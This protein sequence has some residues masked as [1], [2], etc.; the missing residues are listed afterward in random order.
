MNQTQKNRR[1]TKDNFAFSLLMGALEA[2]EKEDD[3]ERLLK[4]MGWKQVD[5]I[6]DIEPLHEYCLKI[7]TAIESGM[8]IKFEQIN[9]LYMAK[10]RKLLPA[11]RNYE[12]YDLR[13]SILMSEIDAV[14]VFELND[15]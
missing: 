9:S 2:L 13:L 1:L 4:A 5:C 8:F 7:A 10:Y 11:F 15:H 6:P 14:K 3:A 12:N